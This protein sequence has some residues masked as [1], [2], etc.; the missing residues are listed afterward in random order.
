MVSKPET[1]QLFY[2]ST[3]IDIFSV[4]YFQGN[5]FR[6]FKESARYFKII[7]KDQIHNEMGANQNI[8]TFIQLSTK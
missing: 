8:R 1:K 4:S 3:H 7:S 2:K 6:V 5:L